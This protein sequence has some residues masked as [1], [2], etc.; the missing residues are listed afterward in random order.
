MGRRRKQGFYLHG[1]R[2]SYIEGA[3]SGLIMSNQFAELLS[4][5]CY[6][7]KRSALI[8]TDLTGEGSLLSIARC[9][10]LGQSRSRCDWNSRLGNIASSCCLRDRCSRSSWGQAGSRGGRRVKSC[11][12]CGADVLLLSCDALSFVVDSLDVVACLGV[13]ALCLLSELG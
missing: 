13:E 7:K 3:T 1:E 5:S 11:G 12:C 4:D 10:N 8:F 9:A 6:R 2:G